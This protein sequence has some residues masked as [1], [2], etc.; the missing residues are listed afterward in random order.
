MDH[1]FGS[2][3]PFTVGIE[4]ELML[5]DPGTGRLA[6]I[7]ERLLPQIE[8]PLG[9]IGHEAYASEIELRSLPS[10]S[11]AEA[12][13]FLERGRQAARAAGATL[14]AAGLHPAAEHGDAQLVDTE[15]Y[16]TVLRE[17]R[18]L[19]QRT[20]ECALHVHVGMPDPAAAIAAFNGMRR[21]LPL[22][23]G[24][25]A[26]SPYWFGVDS[27]LA[28]AR[29]AIIRAFPSRG[30]P[31]ALRDFED[32]ER[33]LA[34]EAAGGGPDDYT[35]IWWDV[36]LHPRLG[37]LEVREMDVQPR[38]GDAGAIAALVRGL[39]REAVDGGADPLPAEA[40]AWSCYRAAR[41]GLEATILHEGG[42]VPVPEAGRAAVELARPYARELGDE[43]ELEGIERI[44]AGGG[45][46]ARQREA[47]AN[48]GIDAVVELLRAE[49][50]GAQ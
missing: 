36:R 23:I 3:E 8:L 4:E 11:T 47:H 7:A 18:G 22:L 20:P 35:R 1:G 13:G 49:T 24:L 45:S 2:G 39:A 42:L 33:A 9:T 15:R 28:S 17:M 16:R 10:S 41:D 25:A 29:W 50:D 14:L 30:V 6:P 31:R 5:L 12:T 40:I 48:G 38:L 37:T 44:L 43:E 27:G 32:Y 46:P 19:I 34:G 21:W 26:G